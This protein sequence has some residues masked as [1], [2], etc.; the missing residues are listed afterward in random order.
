MN[1][2]ISNLIEI[3]RNGLVKN[4]TG[5][6]DEEYTYAG[7]TR[8]AIRITGKNFFVHLIHYNWFPFCHSYCY[9]ID[10]S[11]KEY[12]ISKQE[13]NLVVECIKNKEQNTVVLKMKELLEIHQNE[14]IEKGKAMTKA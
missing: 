11:E 13:Y 10:S 9:K 7:S 5:P 12:K 4:I 8:E 3:I 2:V 14:I 6:Y 1:I